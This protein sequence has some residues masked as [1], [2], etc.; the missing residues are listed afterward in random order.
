MAWENVAVETEGPLSVIT[1]NRPSAY[2]ALDKQAQLDLMEAI[3]AYE[4][5]DGQ[6]V[7]ILTGAGDKAFCAG[8]DLRYQLAGG[9]LFTAPKGF[10]GMTARPHMKKPIIAAVNGV[11]MGGGFEIAL[12]CDII[13]AAAHARFALPEPRV[14]LAALAGG[15]Q[16][17]PRDIGLKNAMGMMLTGRHVSAQ[18][19]KALGFVNEV[20]AGAVLDTAKQWATDI[21][22][23]S[24][25][26][27]QATK[28]AVYRGITITPEE[29]IA[30]EFDYPAMRRMVESAD[31]AE[32]PRAFAEKRTPRWSGA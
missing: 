29:G 19:G 4:A 28:E 20:A 3:D 2:N 30:A 8:M 25:L 9:D 11:A 10:G 16:R 27:V 12:A 22:Q 7:A 32:G 13:I 14:G 31:A 23:C 18:E 17:L 1:I 6:W 21:L 5:D 15:I 24:P 26:A